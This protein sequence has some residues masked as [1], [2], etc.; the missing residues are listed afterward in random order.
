ME[1]LFNKAKT[2]A[3]NNKTMMIC[4]VASVLLIIAAIFAYKSNL[5]ESFTGGKE[6]TA[7][8]GTSGSSSSSGSGANPVELMMFSVDWCPHCKQA[9][10]EWQKISDEYS[11][12]SNSQING[13]KVIFTLVNCTEETPE[14]EKMLKQYSIEGYPTIK[15]L[16]DG[17]IVNFEAKPDY[18]NI[19]KFL[20][21]TV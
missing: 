8:Q 12:T 4:I 7:K 19:L 9:T 16:K 10:P 5:L 11:S 15:L 13:R 21:S 2:F 17:Q 14:I 1:D 20:Q 3:L 6:Y 18:P